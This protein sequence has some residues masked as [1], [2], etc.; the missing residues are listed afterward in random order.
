MGAPQAG[1]TPLF[2]AVCQGKE[3]LA[4][5]LLRAG[6]DKEATDPVRARV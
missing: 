5:V 4:Q 2:I 6:A 1:R 3:A